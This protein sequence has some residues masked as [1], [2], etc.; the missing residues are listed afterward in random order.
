MKATV[1]PSQCG[2]RVRRL[3]VDD[4][5]EIS[6]IERASFRHPWSDAM[7][8]SELAHPTAFGLGAESAGRLLAYAMFRRIGTEAELARVAADPS[9]R[10]QG[11][12][13]TLL[14]AGLK[15]LDREGVLQT[16]LEVRTTNE[17]A[18][19]LYSALSFFE[20]GRRR[21]Y[22]PDGTDAL[23]LVRAQSGTSTGSTS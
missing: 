7:I 16:F 12:A 8:E 22:Y 15:I 18:R 3:R 11:L 19:A 10:R 21:A 14:D 5:S 17:P 20:V 1:S 2:P 13:R 9:C 23:V 6:R 4:G